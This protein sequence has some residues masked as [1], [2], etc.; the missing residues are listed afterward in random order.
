MQEGRS[1]PE[2]GKSMVHKRKG[3]KM[4]MSGWSYVGWSCGGIEQREG[5]V[6]IWLGCWYR[7]CVDRFR[8]LDWF[9]LFVHWSG[10]GR[11]WRV[12]RHI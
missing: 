12:V 10:D 3:G 7:R 2:G 11:Q 9:I 4:E 1:F 8:V 6:P 5:T